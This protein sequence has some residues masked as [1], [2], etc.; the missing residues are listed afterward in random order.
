MQI[1]PS[2]VKTYGHPNT[3]CPMRW[4]LDR[5]AGLP[6]EPSTPSQEDGT[7]LHKYAENWLREGI[8]PPDDKMGRLFLQ[9]IPYLPEPGTERM[10]IE[11]EFVFEVN[12]IPY[13][14]FADFGVDNGDHVLI[15]DHKTSSNAKRYGLTAGTLPDDWQGMIYAVGGMLEFEVPAAVDRW[16]YY[17]KKTRDAWPVEA[18]FELHSAIDKLVLD[19]EPHA[20]EM[21][22]A[23]DAVTEETIQ[24][25][26]QLDLRC[27][28]NACWAYNKACRHMGHCPRKSGK[29]KQIVDIKALKA[30]IEA[31]TSATPEQVAQ[32]DAN[33]TGQI[34]PPAADACPPGWAKDQNG[35]WVPAPVAPAT[36]P[37]PVVEAVIEPEPP[38]PA[39]PPGWV[40]VDGQWVP[41][42]A[43]EVHP[44]PAPLPVQA[45]A[46]VP[47]KPQLVPAAD[48]APTEPEKKKPGR[49][50]GSTSKAS[51]SDLLAVLVEIRDLLKG[52][53]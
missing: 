19:I 21:M 42:G 29:V 36:S 43:V 12:Y 46:P 34:N 4:G 51:N 39:G 53:G 18:D 20:R 35:Q 10:F 30:Q 16:V 6:P 52:Q 50:K 26:L 2:A 7:L 8:A 48:S 27:N 14:G 23:R 37:A 15:G 28:T 17:C 47:P 13:H 24:N 33:Y 31:K 38:A 25:V 1:S 45:P 32:I 40:Q 49:P 9:G 11:R 22:Q 5:L 41:E 44:A 3:G